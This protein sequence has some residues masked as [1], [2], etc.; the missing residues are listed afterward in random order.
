MI[1]IDGMGSHCRTTWEQTK[2]TN[3]YYAIDTECN[4]HDKRCP[5]VNSIWFYIIDINIHDNKEHDHTYRSHH[6]YNKTSQF[7]MNQFY[8][9]IVFKSTPTIRSYMDHSILYT[10]RWLSWQMQNIARANRWEMKNVAEES[11]QF[12]LSHLD[13]YHKKNITDVNRCF[14]IIVEYK[15][16]TT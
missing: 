2:K 11:R 5:Q 10:E 1:S 13:K 15:K 7:N 6:N 12:S 14:E 9:K 16:T 3:L 8:L 4:C